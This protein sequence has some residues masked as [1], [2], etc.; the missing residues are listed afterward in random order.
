MLVLT[1]AFCFDDYF[2][3]YRNNTKLVGETGDEYIVRVGGDAVIRSNILCKHF[4][5]INFNIK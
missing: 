1:F 5:E 4:K 2:E 3:K